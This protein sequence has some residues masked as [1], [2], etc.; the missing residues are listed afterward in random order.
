[1]R[2]IMSSDAFTMLGGSAKVVI[3]AATD[4]HDKNVAGTDRARDQLRPGAARTLDAAAPPLK[5]W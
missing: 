2:V 4:G 5:A 1:M 3:A